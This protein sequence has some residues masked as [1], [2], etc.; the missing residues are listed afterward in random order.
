VKLGP[1]KA[2]FAPG[3]AVYITFGQK[4]ASHITGS[5]PRNGVASCWVAHGAIRSLS[6]NRAEDMKNRYAWPT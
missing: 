4:A 2:I 6:I 5:R 1:S 3:R